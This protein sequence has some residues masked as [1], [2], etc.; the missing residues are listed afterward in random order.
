[1]NCGVA[2]PL[3]AT[4]LT[5]CLFPSFLNAANHFR[6]PSPQ[7]LSLFLF[8]ATP[9]RKKTSTKTRNWFSFRLPNFRIYG[10][11]KPTAELKR[12]SIE[13]PQASI[14]KKPF[15]TSQRQIRSP[16]ARET[17]L[18]LQFFRL[19]KSWALECLFEIGVNKN[20]YRTDWQ[21]QGRVCRRA[22]A[23][24]RLWK[25]SGINTVCGMIAQLYPRTSFSQIRASG[26]CR[27][28]IKTNKS[29]SACPL[30]DPLNSPVQRRLHP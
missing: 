4:P 5:G 14:A 17:T 24:L 30:S 19:F 23:V 21:R 25:V 15:L 27:P 20:R 1:M 9:R 22:S 10:S 2:Q 13:I 6:P 3:S 18:I 26:I 12:K 28:L 11:A 16:A 8:R 7:R 29:I